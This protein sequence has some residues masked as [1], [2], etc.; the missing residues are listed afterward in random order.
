MMFLDDCELCGE[1]EEH[2]VV[3]NGVSRITHYVPLC[4]LDLWYDIGVPNLLEQ[5]I[6]H[7]GWQRWV[8]PEVFISQFIFPA[9]AEAP[10]P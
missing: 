5:E 8:S 4:L 3:R 7:D 6:W 2:I 9:L 1:Y 10:Q